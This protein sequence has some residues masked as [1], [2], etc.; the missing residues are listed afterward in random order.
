LAKHPLGSP[1]CKKILQVF[2]WRVG[3][4]TPTTST[5]DACSFLVLS[6][7]GFL[8]SIVHPESRLPWK[9]ATGFRCCE[10]GSRRILLFP[11]SYSTPVYFLGKNTPVAVGVTFI[12]S[13]RLPSE[14]IISIRIVPIFYI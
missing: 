12:W 14:H 13:K 10:F 7:T 5:M 2:T 6:S 4:L 1:S 3:I 8:Q 11:I 9:H